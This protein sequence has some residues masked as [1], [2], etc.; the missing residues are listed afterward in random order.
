MSDDE[1]RLQDMDIEEEEEE[2]H[3]YVVE[4]LVKHRTRGEEKKKGEK[5]L[6]ISQQVALWSFM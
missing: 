1:L 6:S 2:E 4:K 5:K 3:E